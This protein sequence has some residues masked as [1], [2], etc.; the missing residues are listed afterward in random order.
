MADTQIRDETEHR[1][2][3]ALDPRESVEVFDT[4]GAAAHRPSEKL[5][6]GYDSVPTRDAAG[7]DARFGHAD[8]RQAEVVH[9]DGDTIAFKSTDLRNSELTSA[10]LTTAQPPNL[11]DN[12]QGTNWGTILM[13]IALILVIILIGS[14]L[15]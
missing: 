8:L 4:N 7:D 6:G 13:M 10:D 5:N 9:G 15:F 2:S 11:A 12:A 3:T 14:W 1:Q